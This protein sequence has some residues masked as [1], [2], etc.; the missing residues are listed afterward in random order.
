LVSISELRMNFNCVY[1]KD[2][3][4]INLF[5]KE[6]QGHVVSYIDI[7]NKLSKRDVYNE[8]PS[9]DIVAFHVFSS[10]RENLFNVEDEDFFYVLS[11]TNTEIIENLK[12]L[13]WEIYQ[14]DFVFNLYIHEGESP[15]N[16][17]VFDNVL[18]YKNEE[19]QNF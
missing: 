14:K 7:T 2:A 12:D 4:N 10:L 11:T 1:S 16:S 8:E 3:V 5:L 6:K 9:D 18:Y 15:E 19:T 13:I 17:L